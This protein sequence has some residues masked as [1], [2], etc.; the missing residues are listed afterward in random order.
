MFSVVLRFPS[1]PTVLTVPPTFLIFAL[2][3]KSGRILSK[4]LATTHESVHRAHLVHSFVI[5]SWGSSTIALT[6]QTF[7]HNPHFVHI[8]T[9]INCFAAFS[10]NTRA[11]PSFCEL[12]EIC[13]D[14][15]I[16]TLPPFVFISNTP[17]SSEN[18]F[19]PRIFAMFC[20]SSGRNPVI[21]PSMVYPPALHGE[22][23]PVTVIP[24]SSPKL[25]TL[26]FIPS[27]FARLTIFGGRVFQR[28]KPCLI[29]ASSSPCS[30]AHC[31]RYSFQRTNSSG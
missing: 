31:S 15:Y 25:C 26:V 7:R 17:S 21:L 30:F 5:R 4:Y 6:G 10:N 9:R 8:F 1:F 28:H 18:T 14:E 2:F 23:P 13:P 27:S 16:L 12:T 22:I 29:K 3:P 11:S 24:N 19:S 20:A